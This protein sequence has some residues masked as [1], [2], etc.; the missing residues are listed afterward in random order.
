MNTLILEACVESCDEAILA[1]KNGANRLEL[2]SH[3]DL[4]GLT[5]DFDLTKQVLEKVNIPVKVMVRP[6][7]GDFVYTDMELQKMQ[8]EIDQFKNTPKLVKA[9]QD[10]EYQ[11][12]LIAVHIIANNHIENN[13]LDHAIKA[14]FTFE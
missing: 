8:A 1:E 3:L 7:A 12:K 13:N 2:C 4:D 6:R 11:K 10:S 9:L 5:P 14:V